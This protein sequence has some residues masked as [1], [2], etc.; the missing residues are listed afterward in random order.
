MTVLRAVTVFGRV[1][2]LSVL[3]TS[4]LYV[5]LYLWRW[6]WERAQI[7]GV[8]FLAS[9]IVFSTQL[10]LRRIAQMSSAPAPASG[11]TVPASVAPSRPLSWTEPDQE[12]HIFLPVLLGFGVALSLIAAAAERLVAFVVGPSSPGRRRSGRTV[13]ESVV[14]ALLVVI[15]VLVGAVIVVARHRL[16]TRE[17]TPLAGTRTYVLEVEGRHVDVDVAD[18]VTTLAWFCRDRAHVDELSVLEVRATSDDTGALVVRP[19]LDRFGAARFE[20]CLT[21]AV[22]DRRTVALLD[23]QT[24]LTEP[25]RPSDS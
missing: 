25:A 10:V 12:T 20:G 8:F 2:L 18:S 11:Q 3:A 5:L 16:M 4:G 14:A 7:A 24:D 19:V 1:L 13:P 21:D 6:E 23:V 22:L 17:E 9:L 15:L